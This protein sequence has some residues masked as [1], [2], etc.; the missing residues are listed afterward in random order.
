MCIRD[1][2][3]IE[4]MTS[5]FYSRDRLEVAAD[6]PEYVKNQLRKWDGIAAVAY[7]SYRKFGLSLIHI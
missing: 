5:V 2:Y 1:R 4:A 3:R 6:V 7:E